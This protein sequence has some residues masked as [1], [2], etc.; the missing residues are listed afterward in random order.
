LQVDRDKII[1]GDANGM[2]KVWDLGNYSQKNG[3]IHQIQPGEGQMEGSRQVGQHH[4]AKKTHGGMSHPTQ[5]FL[6]SIPVF[7]SQ[8]SSK[9]N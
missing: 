3:L 2:V 9:E 5:A 6:H 4:L 1:S 8:A 7:Y